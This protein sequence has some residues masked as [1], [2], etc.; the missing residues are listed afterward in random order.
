V[1]GAV[2]GAGCSEGLKS[3]GASML[4]MLGSVGGSVG[5]RGSIDREGSISGGVAGRPIVPEDPPT[6]E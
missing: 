1:P 3:E 2:K 5:G 4:G 6:V